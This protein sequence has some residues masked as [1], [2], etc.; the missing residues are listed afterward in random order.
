MNYQY[1]NQVY[2]AL[3]YDWQFSKDI[4]A[5]LYDTQRIKIKSNQF[6]KY[7]HYLRLQGYPIVSSAFYGYKIGNII[8]VQR[9]IS[10]LEGRV[11]SI[12]EAING[13]KNYIP[14]NGLRQK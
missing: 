10:E 6:R 8:E 9:C 3:S 7:I 11:M 2:Q 12:Q 4:R 14:M 1:A 5:K 13:L